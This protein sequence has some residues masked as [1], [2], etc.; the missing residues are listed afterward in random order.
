MHPPS[1]ETVLIEL[2]SGTHRLAT[3]IRALRADNA[4]LVQSM[5]GAFADE[6]RLT[7]WKTLV[8][9]PVERQDKAVQHMALELQGKHLRWIK[10]ERFK[11]IAVE[12]KGLTL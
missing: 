2:E 7:L 6:D 12:N 11:K 3:H 1:V 8:A 4:T 10:L 5:T 9:A